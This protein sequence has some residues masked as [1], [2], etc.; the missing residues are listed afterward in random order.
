MLV[1]EDIVV[2]QMIARKLI[3]KFGHKVDLAA[4][5][6]EAIE[7]VQTAHYDLVFM[8]VRMPE[9]DGLSATKAIRQ[10][11][12]ACRNIQITAMTANATKDDIKECM[13][14]GMND[15]VS[16]PV[17]KEMIREALERYFSRLRNKPE[18]LK[19]LIEKDRS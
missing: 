10:L 1:V 13:E 5:G 19:V 16:K 15:F 18:Q 4:N 7:A 3:E 6:L 17:N 9:M 12:S 2:N 8:D 14:S 11:T